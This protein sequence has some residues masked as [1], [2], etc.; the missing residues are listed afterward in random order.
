M[1]QEAGHTYQSDGFT[2]P[3]PSGIRHARWLATLLDNAIPI[4]LLKQRIGLD[5][6]ISMIPGGGDLVMA[7]VS[8]YPVWVAWELGLNRVAIGRMLINIAVDYG[9]GLIPVVGDVLD[10]G[11]KANQANLEILEEGYAQLKDRQQTN[12][13]WQPVV[14]VDAV[15]SQS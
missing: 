10:F 9:I 1:K 6:I 13:A 3:E 2:A 5:P 4:P 7:L 8:L 11:W 12:R 14:D 15:P